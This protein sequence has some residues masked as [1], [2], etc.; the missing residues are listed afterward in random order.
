MNKEP[1]SFLTGEI[2]KTP[3]GIFNVADMSREEM[4]TAGYGLWHSSDD[5]QHHIY[6][7]N[8][9]AFAIKNI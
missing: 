4:N 3:R 9:R 7:G 8:N 1:D 5:N 6:A 2:I